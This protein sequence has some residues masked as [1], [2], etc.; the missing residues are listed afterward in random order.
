MTL[1]DYPA[2]AVARL[3]EEVADL[4]NADS[5]TYSDG[6]AQSLAADLAALLDYVE[7]MEWRPIESAPRDGVTFLAFGAFK[8]NNYWATVSYEESKAGGPNWCWHY[9]PESS[10][11]AHRDAFTHWLPLPPPPSGSEK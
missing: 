2:E 1:P 3:R 7:G 6:A 10:C 9:E 5:F 11:T 4:R 8:G